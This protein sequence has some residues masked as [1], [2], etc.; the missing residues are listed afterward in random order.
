MT[1]GFG[2]QSDGSKLDLL[3][4]PLAIIQVRVAC[5]TGIK[6]PQFLVVKWDSNNPHK[7]DKHRFP[8]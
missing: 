8:R 3:L 1:S 2:V 4:E 6:N 5:Q 7:A